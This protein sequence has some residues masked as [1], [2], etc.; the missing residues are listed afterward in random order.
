MPD[1]REATDEEVLDSLSFALN[2]SSGRRAR[3]QEADE[4]KA[5][6]VSRHLLE[7]LKRSG[8]VLMKKPPTPPHTI[9]FSRK[10]DGG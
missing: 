5:R 4:F 3:Y 1:L 2:H 9:G 7:M 8:C 10:A 6:I